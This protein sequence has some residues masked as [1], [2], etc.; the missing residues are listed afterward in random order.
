MKILF[1]GIFE[2][3]SITKL[4]R[5]WHFKAQQINMQII[6]VWQK[7]IYLHTCIHMYVHMYVAYFAL[8]LQ[9][10]VITNIRRWHFVFAVI[11]FHQQKTNRK[12]SKEAKTQRASSSKFEILFIFLS[13]NMHTYVHMCEY[14]HAWL[15]DCMSPLC[16]CINFIAFQTVANWPRN[17]ILL[18]NIKNLTLVHHLE[19]YKYTK[20]YVCICTHG[21]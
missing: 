6:I 5:V 17:Y 11:A 8:H 12:P 1:S 16:D 9:L 7:F 10:W 19:L 4:N 15:Y 13:I 21:F 18:A 14:M 3:F 2:K 20:A